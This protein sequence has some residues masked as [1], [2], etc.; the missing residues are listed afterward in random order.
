MQFGRPVSSTRRILHAS[1]QQLYFVR[2]SRYVRSTKIP[3]LEAAS[4]PPRRASSLRVAPGWEKPGAAAACAR[5]RAVRSTAPPVKLRAYYRSYLSA[6]RGSERARVT[7]HLL[8]DQMPG[9]HHSLEPLRRRGQ[10]EDAV[11]LSAEAV[12]PHVTHVRSLCPRAAGGCALGPRLG[13]D[14][15]V[16]G[17][18]S[19]G[20]PV[21]TNT[22]RA[23]LSHKLHLAAHLLSARGSAA[24]ASLTEGHG[25]YTLALLST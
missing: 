3:R 23:L 20:L 15:R 14:W 8:P 22:R 19:A 18:P 6:A 1:Q 24:H 21:P 12:R 16:T 17:S 25:R 4:F 13:C 2:G 5:V 9:N 7:G 10:P 11:G